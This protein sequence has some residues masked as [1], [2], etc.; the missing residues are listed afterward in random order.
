MCGIGARIRFR[1]GEGANR[2]ARRRGRSQV[3]RCVTVPNR[4][5]TSATSEFVDGEDDRQ[6]RAGGGDRLDRQ[7]IADVVTAGAARLGRDRDPHQ[8]AGP[9]RSHQVARKAV[10]RVDLRRAWS[11]LVVS[12][13]AD[14][15]AKRLL[16]SRQFETHRCVCPR[17]VGQSQHTACP[18]WPRRGWKADHTRAVVETWVILW[19]ASVGRHEGGRGGPGDPRE[20]GRLCPVVEGERRGPTLTERS[21]DTTGRG[22]RCLLR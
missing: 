2:L 5:T 12:E 18:P 20:K 1:Q 7:G 11:D 4:A 21:S 14:G 8:T 9:R 10:V 6:R 17:E 15:F 3:A 19:A 16:L 13:P 22:S